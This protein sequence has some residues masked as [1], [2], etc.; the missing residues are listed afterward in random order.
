MSKPRVFISSTYYDLKQTREDIS[1]FLTNLGYEPVRNEEGSIPYGNREAL[2]SYCYREVQNV[3]ILISIIGGRFGSPAQDS[4]WSIS[5]EELRTALKSGKQV[6]IFIDKSVDAEYGTYLLNKEKEI[7]YKYVDNVKI[8]Q[9]IEEIRALSSNNNIKTFDSSAEIQHYLKEQLAGLFQSYLS[10]QSREKE[11]DLASKLEATVRNLERMVDSLVEINKGSQEGA[12]NLMKMAHPIVKRLSELL[13]IKFSFW[14]ETKKDL[15]N[16]LEK[17][18]WD[19]I[20]TE[21][22]ENSSSQW[23]KDNSVLSV[24]NSL[25]D[26]NQVIRDIKYADWKDEKVSVLVSHKVAGFDPDV[27]LPF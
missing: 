18:G 7:A 27:D 14:L 9:F 12:T 11:I 17:L 3:D 8:Y 10:S 4:Q 16:L 1:V 21:D 20:V 23:N 25:F 24:D 6:Y 26:E 22:S 19:P 15:E 2:S 13:D 5:N